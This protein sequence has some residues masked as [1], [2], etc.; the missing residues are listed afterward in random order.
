[1]KQSEKLK[2]EANEQESDLAYM[3]KMKQANRAG[4]LEYFHDHILPVLMNKYKV[5]EFACNSFRI[6]SD[7]GRID[8]YPPSGKMLI[9]KSKKW[10]VV[11]KE[12]LL[13]KIIYFL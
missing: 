4:K 13:Q 1:M 9:H 3:G 7:K 10:I 5:E 8:V 6:S 2:Q 12:H 11:P